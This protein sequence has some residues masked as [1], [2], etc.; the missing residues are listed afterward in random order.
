VT[1]P[2]TIDGFDPLPIRRPASV[3]ELGELLRETVAAGQGLYPVGGGTALHLGLPPIKPGYAVDTRGLSEV[4]DYPARD[5]TI[6]VRAGITLTKLQQ[7]LAAEGQRLPVDV[8][9]PERATLGGA[10]A[11]NLSGPRRLGRGTLRDYVIG[12]SFLTDAGDEVKGG[13]RVVKNVAGYDL[14]KLQ[15]GALGTLGIVTQLTL[16]VT[17]KPE[18]QALVAFGVNAAAVGP[19]LDRLHA[20]ASRP[21]AVELLNAAAARATGI[22]L[23]EFDPWVIVVGFEEKAVTVSWQVTTLKDELKSA[24]VRDVTEFRGAACEPLW[25]ALTELQDRP[26]SRLSF[27]ANILPSRVA[28]FVGQASAAHS[29]LLLHAHA[30]NGIVY[31]HVASPDLTTD[32][33]SALLATLTPH[34]ADANGNLVVRRCLVEWKKVLPVWGQPRGDRDLM[35][36]IKRTL[37]PSNVFNPGRLFGDL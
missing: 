5:M 34:A 21:V 11:A 35:R 36:T 19:T 10:V 2:L 4:I 20:S 33:A 13:G 23:P 18:D 14:M 7:T 37:D 25:N 17:P 27:K 29:D 3:S 8:P 24:P 15:I 22:K 1:D 32:Q 9:Q 28:A 31:G 16:K 12:V 26:E 30:G 6:T